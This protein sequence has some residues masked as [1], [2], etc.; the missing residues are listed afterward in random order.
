MTI[1]PDRND[2]VSTHPV[3]TTPAG[4]GRP[5]VSEYYWGYE[6]AMTEHVV[7]LSVLARGV[8]ALLIFPFLMAAFGVWLVP[9]TALIGGPVLAKA[10]ASL[11]LLASGAILAKFASRGTRVRVQVDTST[12][13]LREVVSGPFG[14][15]VTLSHYGVDTVRT[16]QVVASNIEPRIGQVQ[17]T[18]SDG[19]TF[20]AGDGA[21]A[22]LVAL[23][24]RLAC[25]CGLERDFRPAVP[26]Q[27]SPLTH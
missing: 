19:V 3:S 25:D 13:E 11:A 26:E 17:I 6:V 8:A 2:F 22:A 1:S 14:A 4:F 12:G 5:K 9:A 10:A 15:I 20:A 7:D 21:V 23:R 24:D 18:L 27:F 16:V